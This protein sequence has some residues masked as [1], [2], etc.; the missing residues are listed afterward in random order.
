M[1]A[2]EVV[3]P[4]ISQDEIAQRVQEMGAAIAE[5]YAGRPLTLL[6]VLRGSA[7]FLAD[8]AR[9]VAI[10]LEIDFVACSSY[11]RGTETSGT[12]AIAPQ[13]LT[14]LRDRDVLIVED[15]V[16]TGLTL[17]ALLRHLESFQP[18]S[19]AVCALLSKPARRRV[20]VALDYVGFEIPD[21]FV[22][23]YGLD[24]AEG[25]RNLPFIGCLPPT[26]AVRA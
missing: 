10:P 2:Y 20:P 3:E 13:A 25:F 11:G 9:A 15:I 5:R 23:G 22:V 24:Y 8:L 17:A 6:G 26:P 18:R 21:H 12:V 19:I 4:L 16:D 14:S 7:F 1:I